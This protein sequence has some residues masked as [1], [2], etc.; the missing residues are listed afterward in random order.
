[1]HQQPDIDHLVRLEQTSQVRRDNVELLPPEV[2]LREVSD[3]V[4]VPL[5]VGQR[6]ELG[7][8]LEERDLVIAQAYGG[9]LRARCGGI[10]LS[11]H[12][13]LEHERWERCGE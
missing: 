4:V 11:H 12:R 2:I 13:R 6:V 9:A 7:A 1:M 10:A 8:L 5:E 3:L